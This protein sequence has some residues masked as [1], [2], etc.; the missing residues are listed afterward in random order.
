MSPTP[1]TGQA[2]RTLTVLTVDDQP[3]MRRLVYH[4]LK[5]RYIVIEA[6]DADAAIEALERGGVD[7]VLLDLHL[8]P[9]PDSPAE[10]LRIQQRVHDLA[11]GVPVV[12]LSSS[13]DP[14]LRAALRERGVRGFLPKPVN[15][16]DLGRVVD[17]V[18]GEC[19]S[20]P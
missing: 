19:G 6:G 7:L 12:V 10:G 18:L 3:Q 4:A 5:A 15:P 11:P 9:R 2:R 8:P 13:T 1:P 20:E 17:E 14:E 16:D